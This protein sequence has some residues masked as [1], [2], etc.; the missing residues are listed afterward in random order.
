MIK[1]TS[2]MRRMVND[3]EFFHIV[4]AVVEVQNMVRDYENKYR[5]AA[6]HRQASP[7]YR[8]HQAD[9]ARLFDET[10]KAKLVKPVPLTVRPHLDD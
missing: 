10:S 5:D 2:A 8:D 3:T 9:A 7:P 6:R 1:I 4:K